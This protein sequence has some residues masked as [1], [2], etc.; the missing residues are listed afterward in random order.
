M[1][2][3]KLTKEQVS[4]INLYFSEDWRS[5]TM[6][7]M[8]NNISL[9]TGKPFSVYYENNDKDYFNVDLDI[10]LFAFLEQYPLTKLKSKI[11]EKLYDSN[12]LQLVW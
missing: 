10:V 12:S 9:L 11:L 8:E 6:K 2:R 1:K 4:V 5:L 3:K 7:E